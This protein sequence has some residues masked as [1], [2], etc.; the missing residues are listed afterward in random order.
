MTATSRSKPSPGTLPTTAPS[1]VRIALDPSAGQDECR[2]TVGHERDRLNR[3]AGEGVPLD[4]QVVRVDRAEAVAASGEDRPA[5]RRD[6][7]ATADHAG[8]VV[9]E[10]GEDDLGR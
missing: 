9:P 3:A 2:R 8:L 10:L 1:A 5:I 4:R 7:R 6:D